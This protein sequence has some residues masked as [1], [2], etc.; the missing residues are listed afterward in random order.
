[1]KRH[2]TPHATN[3][4]PEPYIATIKLGTSKDAFDLAKHWKADGVAD[5]HHLGRTV[6]A[7]APPSNRSGN[8]AM[9]IA[10]RRA[11]GEKLGRRRPARLLLV[12]DMTSA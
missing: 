3:S 5:Q 8:F 10:M 7:F 9:L 2:L 1:M 12:I 4:P 11:F 6:Y